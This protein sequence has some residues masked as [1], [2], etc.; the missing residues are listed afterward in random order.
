MGVVMKDGALPSPEGGG[1]GGR[2]RTASSSEGNVVRGEEGWSSLVRG[3]QPAPEV[4]MGRTGCP[5]LTPARNSS[6]W[7]EGPIRQG[8]GSLRVVGG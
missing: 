2:K 6:G 4:T 3:S 8:D 5:H 1:G 7:D